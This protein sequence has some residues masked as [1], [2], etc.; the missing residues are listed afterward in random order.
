[1]KKLTKEQKRIIYLGAIILVAI[2]LFWLIIYAPQS[3]RLRAI[4][5][6]LNDA[7][8]R[9][10][11]IT[12]IAEGEDLSVVVRKYNEQ[13]I[14]LQNKFPSSEEAVINF[15]SENARRLKID[16]KNITMAANILLKDKIPG[17]EVEE[18]PISMNLS[19]DYRSLGE[20]LSILR[21]DASILARIRQLGIRGEGEGRPVLNVTLQIS[22]YLSKVSGK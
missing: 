9:I 5:N 2:I 3:R 8:A 19:C 12:Q 15:L 10:A 11:E 21:N 20:Y 7:E 18:L 16:V 1:M 13:L 4:K 22:V 6:Q 17:Y 14:G